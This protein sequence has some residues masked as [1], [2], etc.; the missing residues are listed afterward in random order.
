MKFTVPQKFNQFTLED[1][2]IALHIPKK[3][4]H[5]LRMSKDILI[6]DKQNSLKAELAEGDTVILP[7]FSEA[8][9][10]KKSSK[11]AVILFEDENLLI[12]S[13]P[14]GQKVHPNEASEQNTLVNDVINTVHSA[15]VEAVHRLD[16]DTTGI[17]LMAKNAYMKKMLDY[18]LAENQI[19]RVYMGHVKKNSKIAVQTVNAPLGKKPHTNIF[20]VTRTG[21]SAVTHIIDKKVT[22]KYEELIIELETGRTHQIRAHMKHLNAP[23]VGDKLY[24]GPPSPYLHLYGYKVSFK[25]PITDEEISVSLDI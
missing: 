15:Y 5:W 25:H 1:T 13:K 2:L 10:Y 22:D 20:H 7:D 23:L 6:N 21:K 16:V 4:M 14:P 18:M 9:S 19:K 3:E 12:A 24:G 8:S 17:V 11:Q